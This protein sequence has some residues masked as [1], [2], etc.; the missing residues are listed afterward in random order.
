M[1]NVGGGHHRPTRITTVVVGVEGDTHRLTGGAS[2]VPP[3]GGDGIADCPI[4]DVDFELVT[5]GRWDEQ[6]KRIDTVA[7]DKVTIGAV[8]VQR[9]K[10]GWIPA[11]HI[12]RQ[13]V[14][15]RV[16]G[17]GAGGD[18]QTAA[19]PIP[20]KGHDGVA[21]GDGKGN[22]ARTFVAAVGSNLIRP[23][24]CACHFGLI[25]AGGGKGIGEDLVAL[26]QIGHGGGDGVVVPALPRADH[27]VAIIQGIIPPH[28]DNVGGGGVG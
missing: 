28:I 10:I 18:G 16:G 21:G 19:Q 26:A 4:A 3:I 14:G 2:D 27:G 25:I 23:A 8:I 15:A 5:P 9:H 24:A 6:I 22:G 17:G 20:I 7:P 13:A 12:A 11:C 1:N